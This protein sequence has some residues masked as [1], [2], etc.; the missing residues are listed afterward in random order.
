ML[1]PRC[2]GIALFIAAGVAGSLAADAVP[3]TASTVLQEMA[4]A[5]LAVTSYQ[6]EGVSLA[7][8]PSKP[9]P[10]EVG[11]K[12]FFARPNLMRFEWT[13]HHPYPP[14]RHLVTYAATWSDGKNAFTYTERPDARS[15]DRDGEL[16]QNDSLA[17]GIAGATGVSRGTAHQVPVLLLPELGGFALT[18]IKSPTLVGV[19]PF[20]GTLCFRLRGEHPRTAGT[21]ELWIGQKDHLIRRI[22]SVTRP[23]ANEQEEIHHHIRVNHDIPRDVFEMKPNARK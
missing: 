15:N 14:L 19:E 23:G 16:K 21:Y 4:K 9:S 8:D 7:H 22:I 10:D 3:E 5:Y 11:F 13:S 18:Q 17:M 6:D 1:T 12:I 20:D 2:A